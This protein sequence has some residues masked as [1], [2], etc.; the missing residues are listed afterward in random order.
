MALTRRQWRTYWRAHSPPS[1]SVQLT[2]F[3]SFGD[4]HLPDRKEHDHSRES[5]PNHGLHHTQTAA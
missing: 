1:S 3:S 4:L 5:G 2:L